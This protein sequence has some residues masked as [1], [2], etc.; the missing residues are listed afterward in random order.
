MDR[1]KAIKHTAFLLGT[2][3]AG[4]ELFLSGCTSGREEYKIVDSK[5]IAL[6]DEI[7][8][9]ILPESEKS[10]GAKSAGIGMFMAKMISDCYSDAER[11]MFMDG[12]KKIDELSQKAHAKDFVALTSQQRTDILIPLD[13]EATEAGQDGHSHF[14]SLM[15]Q[16]TLLGYFT[17]EIGVT[18]A[19]RYD[20]VPGGYDGC[21]P[22]EKGQTA[23]FGPTS[24]IG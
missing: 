20:P 11:T 3:V 8:E 6:M 13:R 2:S 12:L 17:S 14:F 5:A 4:S 18:Q 15:K 19:L 22:L 21:V 23:W 7:G 9:T 1:R 10:P 16:L 24:A